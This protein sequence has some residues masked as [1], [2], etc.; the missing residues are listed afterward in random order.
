[1]NLF[2]KGFQK[3]T[4]VDSGGGGFSAEPWKQEIHETGHR[5]NATNREAT[6]D[7]K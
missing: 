3:Y 5:M 2:D 4:D 7:G 6:G 1:M